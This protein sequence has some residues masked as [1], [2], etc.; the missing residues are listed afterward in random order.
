MATVE[1]DAR[2]GRAR[3]DKDKVASAPPAAVEAR[4]ARGVLPALEAPVAEALRGFFAE[5][6]WWMLADRS[7]VQ[8]ACARAP[9]AAFEIDAEGTRLALHVDGA[10]GDPD[11]GRLRWSDRSGRARVL[12]W[13]LA[14]ES[15]LMRLSEWL[16][17]SLLPVVDAAEGGDASAALATPG[18]WLDV[19]IED[20]VPLPDGD[21][22]APPPARASTRLWLPADWLHRLAARAEPAHA[23]DPP[24]GAGR[25]RA[26][27]VA[28]SLLLAAPPLAAG[29]WRALRP[30]D[31]IVAGRSSLPNL[32][33][34]AAGQD[35]PL[36][37]AAGGW[38]VRG[39]PTPTSIF[40]EDSTMTDHEASPT[41]PDAAPADPARRLPVRLEFELGRTELS[42]GELADLQPGYVFPLATALEG[43]NVA[44]RANGRDVGRGELVAVGDTLGVR[45]VSW[46]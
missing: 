43:A 9:S 20:D 39:A 18:L 14:H 25:W 30:G 24:K 32:I 31:V 8:V 3:S 45:L 13:S 15:L 46:S 38:S 2:K 33:A 26:L 44:I 1:R 29:D 35:W 17:V 19:A 27:P 10:A 34:R 36:A 28:V 42:V 5:P 23:E 7:A 37:S 22:P 41:A 21:V 16:G 40:H 4:S 11:D 12:A 6:R